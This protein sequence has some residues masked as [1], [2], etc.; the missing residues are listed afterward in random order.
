MQVRSLRRLLERPS[1]ETE[2]QQLARDAQQLAAQARARAKEAI[3]QSDRLRRKLRLAG[4]LS[5]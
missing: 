3:E 2:L 4:L 1:S 5:R